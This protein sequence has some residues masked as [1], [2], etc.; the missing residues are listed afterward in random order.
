MPCKWNLHIT[1][2]LILLLI[3][4]VWVTMK[5]GN[6]LKA[7]KSKFLVHQGEFILL[8]KKDEFPAVTVPCGLI[9]AGLSFCICSTVETLTPLSL[10]TAFATPETRN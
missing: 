6:V 8:T 9:K 1:D 2:I 4:Q 10:D 3:L 7:C 5:N